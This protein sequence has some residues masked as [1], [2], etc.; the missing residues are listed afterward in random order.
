MGIISLGA[1]ATFGETLNE[2]EAAALMAAAYDSGINFF[3]NADVYG[4]GQAEQIMGCALRRL[5]WPRESYLVSSKVFWGAGLAAP[6]AKGLSRKHVFDACHA[7]LKRLR[8]D[9]LDLYFCHRFDPETPLEETVRAMSDLVSQGKVLYWG[10]SEW[11]AQQILEA[12]AIAQQQLLVGPITEQPKYNLLHRQRVEL[13]YLRLLQLGMGMTIWSPLASGFL[14]GK[15][16]HGFPEDARL[17]KSSYQWVL[18]RTVSGDL[19]KTLEL[20]RRLTAFAAELNT[21]LARLAVAWCL[22]NPYVS[23]AI[24]GASSPR[25]LRDTLGALEVIPLLTPQVIEH[26]EAIL[27]NKPFPPEPA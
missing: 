27:G 1:W 20:V 9:Y 14:T 21:N 19:N 26:L 7:A 17:S 10:T 13:E 18:E 3:D 2:E 8:V 6:T 5:G 24:T 15:Y 16:N 22:K 12:R 11:S 25:Q 23:T 4:N